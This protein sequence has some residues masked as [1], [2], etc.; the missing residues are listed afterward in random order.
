MRCELSDPVLVANL[1]LLDGV[2]GIAFLEAV[3]CQHFGPRAMK[4]SVT[5]WS[6]LLVAPPTRRQSRE[7]RALVAG[8]IPAGP[9]ASC[10]RCVSTD[11]ASPSG[12]ALMAD[13]PCVLQRRDMASLQYGVVGELFGLRAGMMYT[14]VEGLGR[15]RNNI[16]EPN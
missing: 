3:I 1:Q 12:Q 14:E 13:S 5:R 7:R 16:V 15:L 6:S 8:K 2:L 4:N 9:P 10:R 11:N